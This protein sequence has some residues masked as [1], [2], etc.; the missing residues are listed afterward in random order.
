ME[1]PTV[2]VIFTE[3]SC[4][5]ADPRLSAGLASCNGAPAKGHADTRPAPLA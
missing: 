3:T 5:F 1:H 2:T 4:A